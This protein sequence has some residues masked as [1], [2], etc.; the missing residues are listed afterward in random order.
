MRDRWGKMALDP[1]S[2]L[3]ILGCPKGHILTYFIL[4]KPHVATNFI[5]H[6]TDEET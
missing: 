2:P 5:P 3:Y 4:T 6:L 1:T